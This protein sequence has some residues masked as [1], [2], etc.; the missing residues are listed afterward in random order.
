MQSHLY[1]EIKRL[2]QKTVLWVFFSILGTNTINNME[3]N[4]YGNPKQNYWKRVFSV[5]Y[6]EN[7]KK[8]ANQ[9]KWRNRITLPKRYI[10]SVFEIVT[11]K[12]RENRWKALYIRKQKAPKSMLGTKTINSMK[13]TLYGNPNQN[14]WKH[15]F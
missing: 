5:F 6:V 8:N 9:A 12:K 7:A 14:Y 4:L 3:V 1:G 15:V 10:L 11:Y 13:V 2:C